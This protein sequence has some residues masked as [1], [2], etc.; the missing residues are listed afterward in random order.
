[1]LMH[2]QSGCPLSRRALHVH[3]AVQ[4]PAWKLAQIAAHCKLLEISLEGEHECKTCEKCRKKRA[5][6]WPFYANENNGDK[7]YKG[8][9]QSRCL[10]D[11]L[12]QWWDTRAT[13]SCKFYPWFVTLRVL[14]YCQLKPLSCTVKLLHSEITVKTFA[15]FAKSET[16]N[17]SFAFFPSP[18]FWPQGISHHIF[19]FLN[20]ESLLL[21]PVRCVH[22]HLSSLPSLT[23]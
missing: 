20:K 4:R 19:F 11:V 2:S 1:M 21:Y 7:H 13:C 6:A 17:R 9:T 23:L 14:S 15:S 12:M 22:S 3:Q 16:H 8:L 5:P 10:F 18:P